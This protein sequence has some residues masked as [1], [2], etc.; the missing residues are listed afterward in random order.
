[1]NARA[2]IANTHWDLLSLLSLVKSFT[3]TRMISGGA[4]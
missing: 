1:M 2:N 4:L 3:S